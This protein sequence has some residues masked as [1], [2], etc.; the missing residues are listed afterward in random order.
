MQ[1]VRHSLHPRDPHRYLHGLIGGRVRGVLQLRADA[2]R[3]RGDAR[4]TQRFVGMSGVA[5]SEA[6][7]RV[8]LR[9]SGLVQGVGFRPY[10]HRLATSLALGG[11]VGNDTR[12][13]F[14]EV[15]G[16]TNATE[17]FVN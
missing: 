13:V 7:V 8:R 14:I 10:V 11:H 17:E 9:V 15:E 2:S 6:A 12:G 16:T 3:G 4:T 1:G 5:T